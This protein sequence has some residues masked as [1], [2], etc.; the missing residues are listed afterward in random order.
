MAEVPVSNDELEDI[1]SVVAHELYSKW[2]VDDRFTEEQIEEFAGY[3]VEDTLF[4]IG[5]YMEKV[6]ELMAEKQKLSLLNNL[7]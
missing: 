6:N 2:A 5:I 7:S 1:V 3:A 4:V